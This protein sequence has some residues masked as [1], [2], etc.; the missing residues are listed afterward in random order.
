MPT[1]CVVLAN[2]FS[3]EGEE[4]VQHFN[5]TAWIANQIGFDLP[6]VFFPFP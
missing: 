1:S 3:G 4:Q 6:T 5:I 2:N